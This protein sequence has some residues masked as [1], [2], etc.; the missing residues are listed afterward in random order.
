MEQNRESFLILCTSQPS[1]ALFLIKF[2]LELMGSWR[3]WVNVDV[4]HA[5]ARSQVKHF[6]IT[7]GK[8][9]KINTNDISLST[10][11]ISP[12][13]SLLTEKM[14]SVCMMSTR[15]LANLL[16]NSACFSATATG[17]TPT[18]SRVSSSLRVNKSSQYRRSRAWK[19]DVIAM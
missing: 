19:K 5:R 3:K 13:R 7:W 18:T 2:G 4:G 9:T 8:K 10:L 6:Q 1:S 15:P 17:S 12:G 16:S 14:V 11:L